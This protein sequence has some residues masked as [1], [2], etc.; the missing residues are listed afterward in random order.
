MQFGLW[1]S[2]WAG[3]YVLGELD[4]VEQK[5]EGAYVGSALSFKSPDVVVELSVRD[6]M[7]RQA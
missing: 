2:H 5:P 4:L 1:P 7:L 3:L 6:C